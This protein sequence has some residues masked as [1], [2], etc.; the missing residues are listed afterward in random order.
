MFSEL[1]R[2]HINKAVMTETQNA[3]ENYGDHY[4]SPHEGYA[5]LLEEVEEAADDL[6]YIKNNL[7]VLWQSIKTND[8]KDTTL[9]TDIEGTAQMLALEAVQ[10]AAVCT[11]FKESL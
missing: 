5:V 10:I 9:L 11:K 6:T 7:G 1:A 8:L 3:K 4:N 2:L